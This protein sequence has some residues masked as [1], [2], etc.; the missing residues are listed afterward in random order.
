MYFFT[1]KVAGASGIGLNIA[2]ALVNNG[3]KVV[4]SDLNVE[5]GQQAD[6]SYLIKCDV[7]KKESVDQMVKKTVDLFQCSLS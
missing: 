2:K 5:D 4:V 6:G 3:A 1:E 7:T